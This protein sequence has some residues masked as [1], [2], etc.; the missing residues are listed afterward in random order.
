M[1]EENRKEDFAQEDPFQGQLM[2]GFSIGRDLQRAPEL[3]SYHHLQP[4]KQAE[5]NPALSSEYW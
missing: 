1:A 5:L 3:K 4:P 2:V